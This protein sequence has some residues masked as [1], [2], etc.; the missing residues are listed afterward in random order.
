MKH[1]EIYAVIKMVNGKQEEVVYTFVD[2]QDAILEADRL[3]TNFSLMI[4]MTHTTYW[5]E[6]INNCSRV[7]NQL[8]CP[9][10]LDEIIYKRD[11]KFIIVNVQIFPKGTTLNHED[12]YEKED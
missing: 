10:T 11:I 7:I 4:E 12:L 5:K 9:V 6:N 3:N 1:Q 2:I 8:Y